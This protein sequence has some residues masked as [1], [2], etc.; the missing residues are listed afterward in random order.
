MSRALQ[1]NVLIDHPVTDLFDHPDD[2]AETVAG[3]LLVD[4]ATGTDPAGVTVLGAHWLPRGWASVP[5]ATDVDLEHARTAIA[6]LR[7]LIE[8]GLTVA[9]EGTDSGGPEIETSGLSDGWWS[10]TDAEADLI[11]H[12]REP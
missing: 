9:R 4:T 5:G 2:P 8:H 11:D 6:L 7:E 1:I 10:I 12:L 3:Y